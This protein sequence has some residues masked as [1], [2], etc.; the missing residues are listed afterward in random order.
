MHMELTWFKELPGGRFEAILDR[1]L[2]MLR[3]G[4][5]GD[6]GDCLVFKEQL[7]VFSLRM[8]EISTKLWKLLVNNCDF[9]KWGLFVWEQKHSISQ[10]CRSVCSQGAVLDCVSVDFINDCGGP[11]P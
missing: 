10:L 9:G 4:D 3:I 7:G 8:D 2:R 1:L 6:S 5:G 11:H